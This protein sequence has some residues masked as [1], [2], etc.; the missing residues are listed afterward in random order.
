MIL[1]GRRCLQKYLQHFKGGFGLNA[2]IFTALREKTKN[3]DTF[4]CH[5][6]LVIDE[7][8]LSE[9]LNAKSSG[10]LSYTFMQPG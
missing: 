4:S 3:M 6:G 5:G 7:I 10:E 1:P 2:N 9:N 8:K